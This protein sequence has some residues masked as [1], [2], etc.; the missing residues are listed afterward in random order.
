MSGKWSKAQREKFAKTVAAKRAAAK[1]ASPSASTAISS[2]T[3]TVP[4]AKLP[5]PKS[6]I[7]MENGKPVI[8]DLKTVQAYV[9]RG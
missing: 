9:K 5:S 4:R 7:V 2:A 6:M 8:Y 3:T 1:K